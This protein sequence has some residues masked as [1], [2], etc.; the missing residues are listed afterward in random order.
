MVREKAI[1]WTSR[2]PLVIVIMMMLMILGIACAGEAGP[3]GSQGAA[4]SQGPAG[5]AG[6]AGFDQVDAIGE[7]AMARGVVYDWG[8]TFD[9]KNK[10]RNWLASGEWSLNCEV[11]CAEA[12]P[13]QINYSMGFAMVRAEVEEAGKSSHGH[14]FWDW[15]ATSAEVVPGDGKETLEIK[16]TIT[17]SGPLK[18]SGIT[19]RLVKADNGH[20]TYFFKFDEGSVLTTEIGG[21]VLESSGS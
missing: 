19:I 10:T 12:K 2:S 8:Q 5:P 6:S 13:E 4:G 20:F 21:G 1:F 9:E 11:A 14:T 15:E 18:T 16:G 7:L 17:G 3:A